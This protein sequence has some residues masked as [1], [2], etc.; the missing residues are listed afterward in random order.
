[1]RT[2]LIR[3]AAEDGFPLEGL[4]HGPDAGPGARAV[5]LV[6]GKTMNFYTCLGWILPAHLTALGWSCL[7]MNRRGHDLG[8]IRESRTSIGGASETFGDSQLDIGGGMAELRRRG[9]KT[10]VLV[11]HS[12][13]GIASAAYASD[14]PQDVAALALCSAGR[15]GRG[16]LLQVSRG[17]MLAGDRHAEIDAEARRLVAAGRGGRMM[18][19]QG[20]WYAITAASW[21]DLSENVRGT[22]ESACRYPGPILA[23]RGGLEGPAQYPAEEIA[24]TCGDRARLAVLPGADHFYNNTEAALATALGE[25]LQTI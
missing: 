17:G 13:G 2:E 24:R 21:V 19:L 18:A 4:V 11:G 5:L 9:F 12:F 1:M 20:W 14:N 16:Y 15:G 8:G 22:V 25:W 3:F 7:A 6:H 10:I 23:L